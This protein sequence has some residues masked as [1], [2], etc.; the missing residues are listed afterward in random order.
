MRSVIQVYS[1]G[2]AYGSTVA[3]A[4][5]ESAWPCEN[6]NRSGVRGRF[7]VVSYTQVVC[8]LRFRAPKKEYTAMI[9]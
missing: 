2:K 5:I 9:T 6:R 8:T 1:V 7:L 4:R 3:P